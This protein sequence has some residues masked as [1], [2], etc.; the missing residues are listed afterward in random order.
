MTILIVKQSDNPVAA[1]PARWLKGE[2]VGAV[3]DGHTFGSA[4]IPSAGNFYHITVTDRTAAQVNNY[5]DGWRHEP[6]SNIDTN[7]GNGNYR[8]TI[9]STGVSSSG[10]N[11]VT[12]VQMDAFVDKWQG[13]YVSHTNSTY[14]FDITSYQAAT[15]PGFWNT[16]LSSTFFADEGFAAGTQQVQLASTNIPLAQ[17]ASA[18]AAKG[19]TVLDN[20]S[21]S[22]DATVLYTEFKDDIESAWRA[23]DFKRRRWN[24]SDAGMT[25]L[26]N[27]SGV[28]SVTAAQVL[29][30]L[31]DGYLS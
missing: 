4:E 11:A 22:I 27:A 21:F 23:I 24:I 9:T 31:E 19:G 20:D 17:V 13:V 12:K 30:Y 7:D 16:D 2:I 15:S 28:M 5:L 26:S 8:I 3:E 1:G 18:V 29:P 6:T 10:K 25:L 14:T